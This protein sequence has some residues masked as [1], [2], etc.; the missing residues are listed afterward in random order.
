MTKGAASAFR[1]FS[2]MPVKEYLM[3][4]VI[5]RITQNEGKDRYLIKKTTAPITYKKVLL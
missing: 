4:D 2:L 1:V 5:S 3:R